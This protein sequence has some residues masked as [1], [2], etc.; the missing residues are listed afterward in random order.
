MR[1]APGIAEICLPIQTMCRSARE[2]IRSALARGFS[3]CRTMKIPRHGNW[4]RRASPA[5]RPFCRARSA[6]FRWFPIPTNWDGAA[7][8]ARGTHRIRSSFGTICRCKRA[9]GTSSRRA[10]MR[11][12][13]E[14]RIICFLSGVLVTNP[15]VSDSVFTQNN[16]KCLFSPRV[17]L[18]WDV[19]GNGK[20]AIRAG[21]GTYYSLID[22]LAFL[23]NSLPP[24][25]GAVSS[26][27]RCHR[28][29]RSRRALLRLPLAV[30]EF[31]PGASTYAPQGVQANAKTPT[32]E[33]WNLRVEQQLNRNTVFACG[34]CR[35]A[36]I[37]RIP[38]HRSQRHSRADLL[39]SHWLHG[40]R[41]FDQRRS[42]H[43]GKPEPC[44]ARGAIYSGGHAAESVPRRGF[45]LVHGR[46]HSY[47]ALETDV[48]H[49]LGQGLEF[50]ANYTWSK[51]LDMNSG[52]TG[53]QAN[54]QAQMVLDRNDPAR[55]WGPSALNITSASSIS[56]LY[57]LPFGAGKQW[58]NKLGGPEEKIVSGWHLNGIATLMTGFPFTPLI[59]SN[60]SGDGDTRNPDRPSLNP[61]FSGPVLLNSPNQW[62]NPNAFALPA[63]GTY[64]NLGRGTLTGP[65]LA[66]MDVSLFKT[67][68][69]T[70]RT[71]LEF[72]A[73]FF[74]V[75][76][77]VNLGLP[78]TTVFSNGSISGSAGLIT[79]TATSPRQIQFGLKL[80]F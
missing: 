24:Y 18:A 16:A 43:S 25:N 39:K 34:L 44:G 6:L 26:R 51:N 58:L 50:R 37:S 5:C 71:S 42:R 68:A 78:N 72:R 3:A 20:T 13:G 69:I 7:C 2:S 19:F 1:P 30:P 14:P 15:E 29:Y 54:N 38:E 80:I 60:R 12:M 17:G 64:G 70:E 79:T 32:V 59:G 55:D 33:E 63:A 56:A 9:S 61:S 77:H 28:S 31:P 66:E 73:E 22:D 10:G 11:R 62:F 41:R 4:D 23:L 36:R 8:S 45:L 74:N 21:F 65:G 46:K 57:E 27:A 40:R 53:A 67:T 49:R 48:E 52:L 76:N 35:I 75:L 47:N